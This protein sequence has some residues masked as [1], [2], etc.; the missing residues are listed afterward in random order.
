MKIIIIII[1][2]AAKVFQTFIRT[3][4]HTYTHY[5]HALALALVCWKTSVVVDYLDQNKLGMKTQ[6]SLTVIGKYAFCVN[7]LRSDMVVVVVIV[8]AK[9]GD[10]PKHQL[11]CGWI[12]IKYRR[13]IVIETGKRK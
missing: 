4:I 7:A 3:Y 12:H 2:V 11:P 9:F 8:V 1:I 5:A 6:I 10:G 13:K